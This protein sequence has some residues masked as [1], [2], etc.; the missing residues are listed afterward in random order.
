M[1]IVN[2]L[3]KLFVG[4]KT[5]K[6]LKSILPLVDAVKAMKLPLVNFLTMNFVLRQLNL[7]KELKPPVHNSIRKSKN[8]KPVLKRLKI[9]MKE[10]ASTTE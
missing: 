7:K 8:I 3:L 9:L 4:D 5:K 6:D 10:N 1:S 2:N